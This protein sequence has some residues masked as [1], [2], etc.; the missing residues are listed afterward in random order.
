MFPRERETTF[1]YGG[2]SY[3]FSRQSKYVDQAEVKNIIRTLIDFLMLTFQAKVVTT[4]AKGVEVRLTK[5]T[6][7]DCLCSAEGRHNEFHRGR[8]V[9]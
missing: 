6:A 2:H 5:Y 8:V 9:V 3:L 1:T 4:G 7:D